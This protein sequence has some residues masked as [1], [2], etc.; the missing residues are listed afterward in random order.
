MTLPHDTFLDDEGVWNQIFSDTSGMSGGAL[1]LDRDGVVVEE[2]HYLHKVEDI[3]Q[4]P[5]AAKVIA[6]ANRLKVPV[7]IVTNQAGVGRGLYDWT[8]FA[9]VQRHILEH[10]ALSGAR[11]DAVYACPHHR[12]ADTPWIHPDHP[13]RKPNPGM[14]L[15]AAAALGIDLA[16]SWIVGDRASDLEAGQR[17]GIAGGLHVMAG[18]GTKPGE[19]DQALAT[20]NA[21]FQAI[22]VTDIGEASRH[23]PLL[24]V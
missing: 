7:I 1:F 13:A 9:T 18:H 21:N 24:Q 6:Q 16:T 19:R 11:V 8:D 14:L 20:G 12:D 4:V 5:A 2:V 3:R 22:G 10:L 17:A 23:I 15:R